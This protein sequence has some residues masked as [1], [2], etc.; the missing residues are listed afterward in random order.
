MATARRHAPEPPPASAASG[1]SPECHALP[2][3]PLHLSFLPLD[4]ILSS[5]LSPS[6]PERS[7]LPPTPFAAATTTASPP[8]R[9]P[10]LR[11]SSLFLLTKTEGAESPGWGQLRRFPSSATADRRRQIR[12]RPASLKLAVHLYRVYVS[13]PSVSPSLFRRSRAVARLSTAAESF[14]PPAMAWPWPQPP[15][16]APEPTVVLTATPGGR[17]ALPFPLLCTVAPFPPTPEVRQ[18]LSSTPARITAALA[19]PVCPVRCARAWAFR[20]CPPPAIWSPE[21]ETRRPPPPRPRRRLNAGG[22]ESFDQGFDLPWVYD[23]W[24][25]AIR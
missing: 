7:S 11:R 16:L 15:Q 3:A 8:R 1:A 6:L 12:P 5:A 18:P 22:I 14:S 24:A 25:P 4:P 20:R 9:L 23:R 17:S 2:L 13:S 19:S 10:K 21:Q